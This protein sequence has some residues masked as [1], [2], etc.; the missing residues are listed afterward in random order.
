[1]VK[2]KKDL[3]GQK[4]GQL[5]VLC[6]TEDYIDPQGKHKAKWHCNCDCGNEVD[7]VGHRLK[8]GKTTSCGCYKKQRIGTGSKKYNQYKIIDDVIIIYTN[9][10][11]EILVDTESFYNIPK[12]REIC[13]C[14]GKNGYIVGRDCENSRNVFLHDI[15]MQPSFENG[16]MVDHIDGRRFDNRIS[17]LRMA[18][19]TQNN[20]NKR[21]R[22]DNTSGVTGVY[23][24]NDRNKWYVQI[25]IG[26]KTKNLGYYNDLK[27]AVRVR[28]IAEKEH[29]GEF[30]PQRHLF[31]H[32]G[33][34]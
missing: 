23:W 20:Q 24:S 32:Y 5:T 27:D 15:I 34:E 25:T 22:S 1:M 29:F 28:L 6:Q 11:E 9:K 26:G 14:V 2:V 30:A 8:G 33:I 13:W 16:E 4:F 19:S 12:I 21:I 17:E 31:E 3:T 10:G 7:V 18:S